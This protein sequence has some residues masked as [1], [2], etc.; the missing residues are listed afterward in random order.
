MGKKYLGKISQVSESNLVTA[1]NITIR[2]IGTK[3]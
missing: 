2:G 3:D 1:G